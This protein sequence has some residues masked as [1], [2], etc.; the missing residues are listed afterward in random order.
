MLSL[1]AASWVQAVDVREVSAPA[2]EIAHSSGLI[3]QS[4]DG[5]LVV[6][7]G[8]NIGQQLGTVGKL[9]P[10]VALHPP[11]SAEDATYSSA[12]F[13]LLAFS[14]P[15]MVDAK[16]GSQGAVLTPLRPQKNRDLAVATAVLIDA[17][18]RTLVVG[19]RTQSTW[20]D[21][22]IKVLTA[23][24]YTNAGA[25]DT[26]FGERGIVTL[27]VQDAGVT[28]AYAAA[29][30]S[31]GRL[32]VAGYNGGRR[33]RSRLGSF[34]DWSVRAMVARYTDRGV[35]DE[36]FGNHGF[37][38]QTI[39]D[40]GRWGKAGR[41]LLEYDYGYQNPKAAALLLDANDAALVAL[42][43]SK[44]GIHVLRFDAKGKLDPEFGPADG[45]PAKLSEGSTV[46]SLLRDRAGRLLA[47]GTSGSDLFVLHYTSDGK[48]DTTFNP[49]IRKTPIPSGLL[50]DAALL[51]R[52]GH[53]LVAATG[54]QN[55]VVARFD[56]NGMPDN[57]FASD[58]LVKFD[59]DVP[60]AKQAGLTLDRE[61]HPIVAVYS[62][63]GLGQRGVALVR[64]A[65]S[66]A[67]QSVTFR[68][69]EEWAPASCGSPI[70]LQNR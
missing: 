59:F 45:A 70:E 55:A 24:R 17:Q 9:A 4:A 25:L 19:W 27:R 20:L 13:C 38:L 51:D 57:T 5:R 10:I 60:I 42:T 28:Q 26:T 8:A 12:A 34:D 21:A 69:T 39:D 48:P 7:T 65:A 61:Q 56:E 43:D 30:D 58:G 62:A 37:A 22:N 11:Y 1:A 15:N 44:S 63:T 68:S 31:A 64:Y 2:A 3:A 6:A 67:E 33:T 29:V 23:A 32:L 49:G 35:L 40:G 47:V 36:S 66:G 52:S 46:S 41:E 18:S 16:F 14:A 50:A 53:L 54:A